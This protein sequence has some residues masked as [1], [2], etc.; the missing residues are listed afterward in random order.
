MTALH[1]HAIQVSHNNDFED[2]VHSPRQ[3]P[4]MSVVEGAACP[5]GKSPHR[6]WFSNQLFPLPNYFF[7]FSNLFLA[8]QNLFH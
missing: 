8:A 3:K 5:D 2:T 6:R 4:A 7:C 1:D